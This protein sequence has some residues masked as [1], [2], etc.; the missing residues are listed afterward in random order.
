MIGDAKH[1]LDYIAVNVGPGSFTGLRIGM[2][3]AKM[4]CYALSLPLV[5]FT[6]GEAVA[7]NQSE[8]KLTVV[9]DGGNKMRYVQDFSDLRPVTEFSVMT[10]IEAAE[11]VRGRVAVGAVE[12]LAA[13]TKSGDALCRLVADKIARGDVTDC[14]RAELLYLQQPQAELDARRGKI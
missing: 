7:Y 14:N 9:L 4:L 1:R 2:T 8:R 3:T 5:T 11:Y 6:S 12:G 13:A 10:P